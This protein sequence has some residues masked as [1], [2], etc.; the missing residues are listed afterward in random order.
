MLK[1]KRILH[2]T[3]YRCR[4]ITIPCVFRDILYGYYV[5]IFVSTLQ[6]EHQLRCNILYYLSLASLHIGGWWLIE[7]ERVVK[8]AASNRPGASLLQ[9]QVLPC[10][11]AAVGL[12]RSHNRGL[13][14]KYY[15]HINYVYMSM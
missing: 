11:G 1:I 12:H 4:D 7:V 6:F 15:I 5:C 14:H 10:V 3:E 8:P 2:Y 9:L 13:I